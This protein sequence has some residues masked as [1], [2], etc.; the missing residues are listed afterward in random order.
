MHS[1]ELKDHLGVVA[2]PHLLTDTVVSP[3]KNTLTIRAPFTE[4]VDLCQTVPQLKKNLHFFYNPG[5]H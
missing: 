3:I 4:V 1:V 2:R 5:L